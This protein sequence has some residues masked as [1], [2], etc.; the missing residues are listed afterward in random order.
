MK[1]KFLSAVAS[2]LILGATTA[3]AGIDQ[4]LND[5]VVEVSSGKS[6]K[7]DS[8]T[9]LYGGGLQMRAPTVNVQP[10]SV[11]GPSV[12]AGCGGIDATLGSL[13]YLDVDQI[14]ALLEGM[15]ANAPGVMFEMALKV[16]CPSCMDTL[17]ALNEMAN[18]INGMNIDSCAATQMAAGWM[19]KSLKGSLL[20]GTNKDY[21]VAM[22]EFNAGVR[23]AKDEIIKIKASLTAQGCNPSDKTCGAKF[24]LE[25]VGTDSF[26]EY[27]M[28]QDLA[29]P[30][31][32]DANFVNVMRYFA[33]DIKKVMPSGSGEGKQQGKLKIFGTMTGFTT[34]NG[35]NDGGVDGLDGYTD[36]QAEA[37]TKNILKYLVGDVYGATEVP[38]V[39]D[40]NGN[41]VSMAQ[42][43]SLKAHFETKL[44]SIQS[45]IASR[46]ALTSEDI[47]FLSMF[48]I[49][50]YAITNRLASMPNGDV[51]L[52]F[53]K[54]DLAR[55]LAYEIVYEYLA[56]TASIAT[57]Q[58]EK[59]D[60]EAIGSINYACSKDGCH[61]DIVSALT[62]MQ[63]GA[64][65]AS[66]VAY[67]LA[68]QAN[69][70]ASDVLGANVTLMQ[71]LNRMQQY[72]LQRSNPRLFENYMFAKT[73][74][75]GTGK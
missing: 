47:G 3:E 37:N 23:S 51:V 55:A 49:P 69:R 36:V 64:R 41:L 72:S 33:G 74:T 27:T 16:I 17:N 68:A 56:R 52:N 26:L 9:L 15:M 48:R 43:S 63:R 28:M 40:S 13:S 70:Y 25:D 50:V 60:P 2:V 5:A 11:A 10:F 58:K 59:M 12:K 29:D 44:T 34:G 67:S 61:S 32:S 7:T 75:T 46:S 31:F 30:Y 19:E 35:M 57:I 66:M 38:K 39:R 8:G 20:D 4:F 24:F 45:R 6:I 18:Q 1:T 73:L 54:E 65:N 53:I 42:G 62:T 21:N 14:V 71:N 22:K